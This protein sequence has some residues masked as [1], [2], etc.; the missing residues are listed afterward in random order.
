MTMWTI[1]VND[2]YAVDIEPV[3][4]AGPDPWGRQPNAMINGSFPTKLD[5]V[6]HA[7]RDLEEARVALN[8]SIAR[9]KRMRRRLAP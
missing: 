5:A 1:A 4:K 2:G 7:L 9:L 8:A 6:N 3:R